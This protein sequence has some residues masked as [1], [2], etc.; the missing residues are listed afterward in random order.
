M[1]EFMK[2]KE[3]TMKMER[4]MMVEGFLKR[5]DMETKMKHSRLNKESKKNQENKYLISRLD[6]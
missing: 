2:S 6:Y 1:V 4:K 5:V 3:K